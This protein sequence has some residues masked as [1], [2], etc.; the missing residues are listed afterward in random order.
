MIERTMERIGRFL[1]PLLFILCVVLT[2]TLSPI[3]R[4]SAQSW[5]S[6]FVRDVNGLLM[7]NCTNC[8]A[9]TGVQSVTAGVANITIGGTATNPTVA[10]NYGYPNGWTTQQGFIGSAGNCTNSPATIYGICLGQGNGATNNIALA[11][12]P[13]G[14]SG[15]GC[16]TSC[17]T[18]NSGQ[19]CF[20]GESASGPLSQC[21]FVDNTG[22]M[23]LGKL[24]ITNSLQ[25]GA[26]PISNAA[27][28]GT[29]TACSGTSPQ[30]GSNNSMTC[31][32]TAVSNAAEFDFSSA[33]T[34]A[35]ICFATDETTAA[36]P[37]PTTLSTAKVIFATSGASDVI[38]IYC[39]GNG[40]V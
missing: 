5:V 17:T 3:A 40:N 34:A 6:G 14:A 32:V 16:S 25:M 27:K 22:L 33:Y 21:L 26:N 30:T 28:L 4:V 12:G 38:D 20:Y 23:N 9:G 35:P 19:E 13:V 18:S 7:V 8:S 1:P 11:I 15:W 10:L 37:R 36:A 24:K 39:V 29:N 31:H 2:F